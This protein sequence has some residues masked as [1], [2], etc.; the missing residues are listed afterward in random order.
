M[1]RGIISGNDALQ[2]TSSPF[3][4]LSMYTTHV[5]GA[6][7]SIVYH[8]TFGATFIGGEVHFIKCTFFSFDLEQVVSIDKLN[9]FI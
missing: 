2:V 4:M 7:L 3:I 9:T 8:K 6:T 5:P 1:F